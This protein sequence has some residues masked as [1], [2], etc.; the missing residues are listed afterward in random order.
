M[1]NFKTYE[2]YTLNFEYS[3][4]IEAIEIMM[5]EDI[6]IMKVRE[7][8]SNTTLLNDKDKFIKIIKQMRRGRFEINYLKSC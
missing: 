3:E 1:K 5:D 6:K 7:L 4:L 8:E 2:L